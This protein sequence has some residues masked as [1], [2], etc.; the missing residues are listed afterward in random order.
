MLHIIQFYEYRAICLFLYMCHRHLSPAKSAL[1]GTNTDQRIVLP[2]HISVCPERKMR[3]SEVKIHYC[4]T[5]SRL[6]LNMMNRS[7]ASKRSWR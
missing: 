6:Q 1:L 3:G 7:K 5:H 2:I 4:L